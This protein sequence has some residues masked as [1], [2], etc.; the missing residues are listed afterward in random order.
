[1]RELIYNL[2]PATYVLIGVIVLLILPLRINHEKAKNKRWQMRII[3]NAVFVLI[4]SFVV[5]FLFTPNSNFIVINAIC[6]FILFALY[7][8]KVFINVKKVAKSC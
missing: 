6:I 8:V 1:M 3:L 4:M 5:S 7:L 2:Q